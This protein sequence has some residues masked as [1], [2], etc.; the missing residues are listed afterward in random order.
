MSDYIV[1]CAKIIHASGLE[2][3]MH[4]H[5]TNIVGDF[6]QICDLV[7]KCQEKIHG[8]GVKHVALYLR[9]HSRSDRQ[10]VTLESFIKKVKDKF[11]EEVKNKGEQ[12]HAATLESKG[13]SQK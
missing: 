3:V 12:L 10:D 7:A 2:Y 5:G 9:V 13:E 8:M 1:E 4:A 6:G 11:N